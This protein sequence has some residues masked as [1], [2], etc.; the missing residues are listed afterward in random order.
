MHGD[1]HLLVMDG[2]DNLVATLNYLVAAP[3]RK[4]WAHQD[5]ECRRTP[6]HRSKIVQDHA[7]IA[8]KDT[9][10]R[11]LTKSAKGAAAI[12]GRNV[13]H[14]RGI[15]SQRGTSISSNPQYRSPW[16]GR[17]RKLLHACNH[18]E[19]AYPMPL[20][21]EPHSVRRTT[22]KRGSTTTSTCRSSIKLSENLAER[23]RGRTGR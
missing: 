7:R 3:A 8:V 4:A 23:R 18:R 15:L 5:H 20:P 17:R 11:N 9:G 22:S 21:K 2:G 13:A 10:T 16:H 14:K 1:D 6:H 19:A 12:S